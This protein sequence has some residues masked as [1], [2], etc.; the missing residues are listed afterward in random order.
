MHSPNPKNE[1][2]PCF[3]LKRCMNTRTHKDLEW[4][5][6]PERNTLRLLVSCIAESLSVS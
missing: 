2:L 1:G 4:F 6:S 5:G 3:S